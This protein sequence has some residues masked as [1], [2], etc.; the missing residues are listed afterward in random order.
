VWQPDSLTRYELSRS[1][2]DRVMNFSLINTHY[3]RHIAIGNI[4]DSTGTLI[5]YNG[6]NVTQS[7]WMRPESSTYA[8]DSSG[9]YTVNSI[10]LQ[11]NVWP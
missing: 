4:Y 6:Y 3:V 7:W 9:N 2:Y 5:R 1:G 10:L 11:Q 8:I